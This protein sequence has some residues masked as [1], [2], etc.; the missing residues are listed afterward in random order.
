MVTGSDIF[1]L[2]ECEQVSTKFTLL[3]AALRQSEKRGHREE[4]KAEKTEKFQQDPD[5]THSAS[6]FVN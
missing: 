4:G 6:E 1:S 3:L 5:C 2:H